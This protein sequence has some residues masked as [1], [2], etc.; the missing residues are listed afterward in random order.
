MVIVRVG[1]Y[2]RMALEGIENVAKRDFLRNGLDADC[3]P[4]LHER[5]VAV[6]AGDCIERMPSE[7]PS[8]RMPLHQ[9]GVIAMGLPLLDNVAVEE[10]AQVCAEEGRWEFLVTFAPLRLAAAPGAR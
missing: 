10:L 7:Y 5:E 8:C 9:I 3:L 6:Y 1:Q 4:W 2:P